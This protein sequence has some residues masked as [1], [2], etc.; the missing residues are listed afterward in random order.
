MRYGSGPAYAPADSRSP[1]ADREPGPVQETAQRPAPGSAKKRILV[2]DDD[3]DAVYL[4]QENLSPDEFSIIGGRNGHDGLRMAHEQ[5]PDAIL[6]DIMLPETDGWQILHLLKEDPVTTNIPVILLTIVDRKALGFRLG[7]AAYLLKPLDP[8]AV[9]DALRRVTIQDGRQQ[10]RVLVVDDDPHVAD[11]LR[12]FLPESGFS[13][14][15]ALDG[16][17]GLQAIEA[18]RP[19]VVLL[20]IVMPRLDGFGVIESLRANPETRNL[21]IIVISAKEL[22]ETESARLKETVASVMKKQGFQG[23]KLL[24]EINN[25]L[26]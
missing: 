23:E 6:L 17:A 18:N 9:R 16:V 11:M 13:L 5:H 25:V 10:K 15:S 8:V 26:A 22:T 20:D 7:A 19:D 21:P 2:I 24:Q 12:Q 14:D 1:G 3:P 4:L